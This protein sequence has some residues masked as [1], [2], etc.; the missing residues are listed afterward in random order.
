MT[1]EQ[2]ERR[3]DF[4]VEHQTKNTVDI[5]RLQEAQAELTK[6]H[7]HLTEALTSVVGMIGRLQQGQERADAKFAE[8]AE[9]QRDLSVKHGETDERLNTLITVVERYISQNGGAPRTKATR[10]SRQ[11]K[12]K[13]PRKK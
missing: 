5:Q 8:L 2:F 11:R 12:I 6:K 7:N 13:S 4:I 10:P 3:M 1:N 9:A